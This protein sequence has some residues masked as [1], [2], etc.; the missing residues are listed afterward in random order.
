M[1]SAHYN[2]KPESAADHAFIHYPRAEGR[3]GNSNYIHFLSQPSRSTKNKSKRTILNGC[4]NVRFHHTSTVMKSSIFMIG[5]QCSLDK[6]NTSLAKSLLKMDFSTLVVNEKNSTIVPVTGHG[7]VPI[8]DSKV[9]I[10]FGK[11]SIAPPKLTNIV[12]QMDV[13]TGVMNT[14]NING[15]APSA[16]YAH[17]VA[18]I[19]NKVYIIGGINKD[20]D[21]LGEI[22]FIDLI[23]NNWNIITSKNLLLPI[24][25]HSTVVVDK[26]YLISCFG[27]NNKHELRND[28]NVFD[29]INKVYIQ[30][31][32]SGIP[33]SP[34][35]Y[36]SMVTKEEDNNKIYIFGGFDEDY[37]GNND[38]Y[39]LDVTNI[40]K[41]T[42]S[43]IS[44]TS[45]LIPSPRGAHTAIT[46]SEMM[47]IWGGYSDT[48]LSDSEPHIFDFK[49]NTW[50]DKNLITPSFSNNNDNNN[51][52]TSNTSNNNNNNN[53]VPIWQ[54]IVGIV[55]II[56]MALVAIFCFLIIRRRRIKVTSIEDD[57]EIQ[58]DP[59]NRSGGK[60][61]G[62]LE[63]SSEDESKVMKSIDLSILEQITIE[64]ISPSQLPLDEKA[65]YNEKE[66]P[67]LSEVHPNYPKDLNSFKFSSDKNK[68]N[69]I[70]SKRTSTDSQRIKRSHRRTSSVSLT[71]AD[72][73]DLTRPR[74]FVHHKSSLS[75]SVIN[76]ST[77]NHSYLNN[78]ISQK[79]SHFPNEF[80]PISE[81]N[82]DNN[83]NNNISKP[84]D[85]LSAL[86]FEKNN[87]RDSK[88]TFR[89]ARSVNSL[90]WV[91]FNT[92]M[93][94]EQEE[95]R[96]SLHVRNAF[97]TIHSNVS[98]ISSVS[99]DS[100]S[101]SES[102]GEYVICGDYINTAPK[103]QNNNGQGNSI[104]NGLQKRSISQNQSKIK[105]NR[106]TISNIVEEEDSS[107]ECNTRESGIIDNYMHNNNDGDDNDD[108]RSSKKSKRS[109]NK[110]TSRVSFALTD[111]KIE[112]YE[113]ES[114]ECVSLARISGRTSSSSNSNSIPS[115]IEEDEE[116]EADSKYSKK[117]GNEEILK[118]DIPEIVSTVTISPTRNS[119]KD[120]MME[121]GIHE[122]YNM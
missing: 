4:G 56:V 52:D 3:L 60:F 86:R 64:S 102:E 38:L 94:A 44:S 31:T 106:N 5:G 42:W 91:G 65:N 24:A 23:S 80:D 20:N 63:I 112:Y 100:R 118:I 13:Q 46:K 53:S 107:E 34:R 111:E 15:T 28:C 74:S 98:S 59:F 61:G 1:F 9:L 75:T 88:A 122:L 51:E 114:S 26:K 48:D 8:N 71:P 78:S 121:Q 25:G 47:Y 104:D 19:D 99:E 32:I 41:L 50:I 97:S 18:L 67:K 108:K 12:Q 109:S 110:R 45:N 39:I 33:P 119:I 58:N 92:T 105:N 115:I 37:K 116:E 17:T 120:F 81:S 54:I 87:F 49:S 62:S 40:R 82:N 68:L 79:S 29:T 7:A 30:S 10:L 76:N 96:L 77:F 93:M 69:N 57:K 66:S 11:E 22:N 72:V 90:Q 95:K 70:S 27:F 85:T 43:V 55:G 83:N 101:S 73:V 6:S 16:R 35:S 84:L 117:D 21:V 103:F 14:L 2:S 113:T 36:S 89:S